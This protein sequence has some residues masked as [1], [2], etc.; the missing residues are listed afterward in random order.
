MG[1]SFPDSVDIVLAIAEQNGF[2][3]DTQVRM[4]YSAG[5][6]DDPHR[7]SFHPD[8]L[9]F[10]HVVGLSGD[11]V[12]R[13][14]LATHSVQIR[15]YS[16]SELT[17]RDACRLLADTLKDGPQDAGEHGVI[18][19][20]QATTPVEVDSGM[21]NIHQFNSTLSCHVRAL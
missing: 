16:N 14:P 15:V 2:T 5:G 6:A 19:T 18:D 9:P 12:P 17:A 21:P 20:V 8:N 10:A 7:N 4:D 3:A 1:F 13:T 11:E